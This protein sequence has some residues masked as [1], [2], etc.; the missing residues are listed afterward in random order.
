MTEENVCENV[1]EFIPLIKFEDDYEI[2]N[3]PPFTIRRKRDH[4]E[5]KDTI[6]NKNGYIQVALNGK[7]Y[8][9]H[10][11]ISEQFLVNRDPEHLT[12]ID[13]INHDRTDYHLSNLRWVSRSENL[14]NRT[15]HHGVEY[16]YVDEIDDK[17]IVINDYGK[18]LF[19]DYYYDTTADK[20]YFFNGMQYRELHINKLK[21][22]SKF[23]YMYS[24]ENKR[25][26]VCYSKFK[27]LYGL[28]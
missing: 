26:S 16:N 9:K 12:E 22:G 15:S 5:I 18:H 7:T 28:I 19:E 2:L 3:E 10:R 6:N 20:F 17:S 27:K 4:Y 13:H 21:N 14:K 23:V 25:V 8:Y 24:T 11:L 1:V